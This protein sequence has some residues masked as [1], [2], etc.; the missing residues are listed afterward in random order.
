MALAL[1]TAPQ[2]EPTAAASLAPFPSPV[3]DAGP[4]EELS[5]EFSNTMREAD[6]SYT[7]QAATVPI[8]YL[9]SAGNWEPIDNTL[10]EAP[11][12]TYDVQNAGNSFTAKLPEDPRT[13]PVKFIQD[14]AWVTMR[15]HGA[16]AVNADVAGA[17]ATYADVQNT[18]GVTYEVVN[19]GLKETITLAAPPT[20]PVTYA[21]TIDTSSGLTPSLKS[22]GS[23][24]FSNG[25][26]E[27]VF[28]IPAGI[29]FDAAAD[30]AQSTQVTYTLVPV[31]SAWKLTVTP[32]YGWLTAPERIYPVSIDP[33]LTNQPVS[34]DCW[35]NQSSPTTY[36]C[37]NPS[38]FIRV[39]RSDTSTLSRKR[40]LLDFNVSN[41]PNSALVTDASISLYLDTSQSATTAG[42]DYAF[43]TAGKAFD[44]ANWN[45]AGAAGS[46][47]G[48]DPGSTAYGTKNLSGTGASAYKSF[49]GMGPLV[50]GWVDGSIPR[51]G[52]VLKQVG[53][54][55]ANTLY[56]NSSS[57]VSANNNKRPYLNITYVTPPSSPT[58]LSATPC[59]EPCDPDLPFVDVFDPLLGGVSFDI[60]GGTIAYQWQVR[61]LGVSTIVA[62]GSGVALSGSEATWRIPTGMLVDK[63]SYQFRMSASDTTGIRWSSWKNF[64]VNVGWLDPLGPVADPAIQD[65][66]DDVFLNPTVA[67]VDSS[68]PPA[69]LNGQIA[70]WSAIND[71][72]SAA[73]VQALSAAS[74]IAASFDR[75]PPPGGDEIPWSHW[76]A[77]GAFDGNYKVVRDYP[78]TTLDARME[79]SYARLYC[80]RVDS[81]EGESTFGYRHIKDRHAGEWTVKAAAM[82]RGWQDLV[83]WMIDWVTY[84]PDKVTKWSEPTYADRFCYQRKFVFLVDDEVVWKTRA[85]MLTG[86]TGVRIM[87]FFPNNS[88]GTGFCANKGVVVYPY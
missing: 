11:G 59:I 12:T 18:D 14:G 61:K 54:T 31:G 46:W 60:D 44:S 83:A 81:V 30:P 7:M 64:V 38:S 69:L 43:H 84:D 50:Q 45:T 26:G 67:D 8:N 19:T 70:K 25:E 3:D 47:S 28:A 63:A 29:M 58:I 16:Q 9:D 56:F 42:A 88:S 1:M 5:T 36:Y 73:D 24:A 23:I 53:E 51:R 86:R 32:D 41:I 37:G 10:V 57:N 33:T 15:M 52:L 74:G 40:G 85:I 4:V 75:E 82:G 55:V 66:R 76:A 71:T 48:G 27:S 39:G 13:T 62:S 17:E 78:R 80:G 77:C 79:R 20:S 34:R 65:S 49:V 2:I 68:A 35:M 87:T 22:D 72:R 6:G 21:Y